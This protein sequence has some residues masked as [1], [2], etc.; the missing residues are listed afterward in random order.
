MAVAQALAAQAG[1]PS[2]E[3]RPLDRGLSA[4]LFTIH[5]AAAPEPVA[6]TKLQR[7]HRGKV[8]AEAAA[9]AYLEDRHVSSV[10]RPLHI[11]AEHDP[12]ALVVSWLP[13]AASTLEDTDERV[14]PPT[15]S[16]LGTWTARLHDVLVTGDR[17]KMSTDPLALAER[18]RTQV[19]SAVERAGSE[20][21]DA[22]LLAEALTWLEAALDRHPDLGQPRRLIHRDLRPDNIVLD[23]DGGFVGVVDF[24]HAAGADPA[25]DFAKLQWWCFDRI[26][27]LEA[28]F[29]DAYAQVRPVPAA[30]TRRL[31]RIFEATTLLAYFAGKHDT[32]EREARRQLEAELTDAQRPKWSGHW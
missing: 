12:P 26:P 22:G 25:W 20:H 1:L 21:A 15:A 18:M 32:Y 27:G 13:G 3:V 23:A 24:E 8:H 30:A 5:R 4:D 7:G 14:R 19:R 28:P 2:G 17:V 10:P 16:A 11:A 31:F 6:V 29:L 9:L